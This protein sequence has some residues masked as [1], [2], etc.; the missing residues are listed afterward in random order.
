MVPHQH[1]AIGESKK[2]DN[3]GIKNMEQNLSDLLI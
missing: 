3:S 2:K 1:I